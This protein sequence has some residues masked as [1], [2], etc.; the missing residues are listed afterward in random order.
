[1]LYRSALIL[2]F[3]GLIYL[4]NAQSLTQGQ[5][6]SAS[7]APNG[8][9]SF[10]AQ[11]T[12]S[13]LQAGTV[14]LN[15]LTI[16]P[17]SPALFVVVDTESINAGSA[18]LAP[19]RGVTHVLVPSAVVVARTYNIGVFNFGNQT[20]NFD[21]TY[22]LNPD[23][24]VAINT[25]FEFAIAPGELHFANAESSSQF[26][27]Q[28][29]SLLRVEAQFN[30]VGGDLLQQNDVANLL[31]FIFVEC[32]TGYR[33]TG[34]GCEDIDECETARC[35]DGLSCTNLPGSY[36]CTD[37][38]AG[39][40]RQGGIC[41]PVASLSWYPNPDN[42]PL[43][44]GV[45]QN[46]FSYVNNEQ[47]LVL[48]RES[49]PGD[50]FFFSFFNAA[51][52]T[53]NVKLRLFYIDRG[54]LQLDALDQVT[55]G[56]NQWTLLEAPFLD[57]DEIPT[58]WSEALLYFEFQVLNPTALTTPANIV[59]VPFFNKKIMPDVSDANQLDETFSVQGD[60]SSPQLVI[61]GRQVRN[62]TFWRDVLFGVYFNYTSPVTLDISVT[63][64]L[65]EI[66]T[67][68]L[69]RFTPYTANDFTT[70]MIFQFDL[71][72]HFIE[73]LDSSRNATVMKVTMATAEQINDETVFVAVRRQGLP[74]ERMNDGLI[75][76]TEAD[77]FFDLP[78]EPISG[79]WFVLANATS[80]IT[81]NAYDFQI[82]PAVYNRFDINVGE[83]LN[84]RI[85]P[86]YWQY[87]RTQFES[88]NTIQ[89]GL[90]VSLYFVNYV[91]GGV[92]IGNR[93]LSFVVSTGN[94]YPTLIAPFAASRVYFLDEPINGAFVPTYMGVYIPYSRLPSGLQTYT[95][96]VLA[97]ER[98]DSSS[99]NFEF[100]IAPVEETDIVHNQQFDHQLAPD[101]LRYYNI[102]FDEVASRFPSDNEFILHTR[103]SNTGPV[104]LSSVVSKMDQFP[105]IPPKVD[106]DASI[107]LNNTQVSQFTSLTRSQ[108]IGRL[109]HIAVRN[110]H[111]TQAMSYSITAG[112]APLRNLD[113]G[114]TSSIELEG[115]GQMFFTFNFPEEHHNVR[116]DLTL[117]SQSSSNFGATITQGTSV[118]S[119]PNQNEFSN[120][121]AQFS[122]SF[123][124]DTILQSNTFHA[125]VQN[126]TNTNLVVS[127]KITATVLS[128]SPASPVAEVPVNVP[129]A[130]PQA[131]VVAEPEGALN[132][133]QIWGIVLG[134][135]AG[136]LIIAA[137][138]FLIVRRVR[139][140]NSF[141]TVG[142]PMGYV[143]LNQ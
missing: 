21:V 141:E 55:V 67:A 40:L 11:I 51:N 58:A 121:A 36:E 99:H 103:F 15:V 122:R 14:A 115:R 112:F 48:M 111:A 47:T 32:G 44:G 125:L 22:L 75:V 132:T 86:S 135:L 38:P 70:S 50:Y 101:T 54:T 113:L 130:V 102:P 19:Y 126:P 53:T 71:Q 128:D 124:F 87:Y 13:N 72:P 139:Q 138:I 110:W 88:T 34:N 85:I 106:G 94:S 39:F 43:I 27:I 80:T 105:L 127:L 76:G 68:P 90:F 6:T 37:C 84:G 97:S 41:F 74:T 46:D 7:V 93:E 10:T 57:I 134:S 123:T 17:A 20:V 117:T 31:S 142:V 25:Q 2:L 30:T 79:K 8:F 137:A 95:T 26:V 3:C 119:E 64:R 65:H 45:I 9:S 96:G 33:D 23:H 140:R 82:R 116:F 92:G 91:S 109:A 108:A 69:F 49:Y 78:A 18:T 143:K 16:S 52:V 98:S 100:F 73:I 12:S 120:G 4:V 42:S 131:D 104:V 81:G 89:K 66:A 35:N 129:V 107:V 136:A 77:K 63:T 118:Y 29:S 83:F 133:G 62:T 114:T 1:M 60:W 28:S 61:G 24:S 5:L 56:S 59:V